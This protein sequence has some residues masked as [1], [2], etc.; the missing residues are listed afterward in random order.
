MKLRVIFLKKKHIYYAVLT[1][2]ILIL[3]IILLLSKKTSPTFNTLVANNKLVQADLNGDGKKDILYIKTEKDK[4]Y[5]EVNTGEKS[6]YL[7]PDKKLPTSGTFDEFNPLKVTLMDITRDKT[8]EI[9]IQSSQKETPVQHVF[10]WNNGGFQDIFCGS[11]SIIG[12]ADVSNNKTPKFLSGKLTANKIEIATYM[13][14]HDKNKLENVVFNYKDNFM[15]RDSIFSLIKYIEA[16]PGNE[17][18]KPSNIFYPGLSGQDISVIGKLSGENNTYIF[19]NCVF[20]DNKSDKNGEIS[21]IIW[22]LNFKAVSNISKD[23]IKNYTLNVTLKPQGNADENNYYKVNS[24]N[25]EQ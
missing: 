2:I 7:E 11:N 9:F 24:I 19:Q 16:L 20:K 10:L 15:G 21:E 23:K 18:N 5:M 8:P 3:L 6:L 25:L 17:G 13:Y 14:M 12:F 22:T 4:Y 1:S